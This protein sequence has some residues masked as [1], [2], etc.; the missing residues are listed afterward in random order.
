M[1]TSH[2]YSF[3]S[4]H[5]F[6]SWVSGV[7]SV[8]WDC[9][10]KF[11]LLMLL[12]MCVTLFSYCCLNDIHPWKLQPF[13]FAVQHLYMWSRHS[14]PHCPFLLTSYHTHTYTHTHTF[15]WITVQSHSKAICTSIVYAVILSKNFN[16]KYFQCESACRV[17]AAA[18]VYCCAYRWSWSVLS[19][20]RFQTLF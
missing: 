4:R 5:V 19:V 12:I 11:L 16:S 7:Q 18:Y 20:T 6:L 1:L 17:V 8:N 14:V 9:T 3:Y 2:I 10:Y 13:N 15:S